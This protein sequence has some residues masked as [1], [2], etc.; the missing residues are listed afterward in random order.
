VS[1]LVKLQSSQITDP[2]ILRQFNDMRN[3]VRSMALI[4][5]RLSLSEDLARID[6]GDYV[7]QLSAALIRGSHHPE[8]CLTTRLKIDN[9]GLNLDT[10]IPCGLIVNELMANSLKYA[11]PPDPGRTHD[12]IA[13]GLRA[14]SDG[15]LVLTVGDNGIG[16]PP[17]INLKSTNTMGLQVVDILVDQLNGTLA[18][19]RNRGT[20]FTIHFREVQLQE[21]T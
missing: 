2:M 15:Q 20:C 16:L 13:I 1:S 21:R 8:N 18:V 6:F 17:G 5:E 19:D 10:A 9:H 7:K 11:F 14:C 3:R 12:E 4:Y